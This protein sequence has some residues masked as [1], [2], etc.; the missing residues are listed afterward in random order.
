MALNLSTTLR[1][2]T[3]TLYDVKFG[4]NVSFFAHLEGPELNCPM[5]FH[6]NSLVENVY[7]AN[8][9]IDGIIQKMTVT[10]DPVPGKM[11]TETVIEYRAMIQWPLR[12]GWFEYVRVM[13]IEDP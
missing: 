9:D 4:H 7:T 10:I 12:V 3:L 5:T 2:H 11:E 6:S 8:I 1:D 13:R